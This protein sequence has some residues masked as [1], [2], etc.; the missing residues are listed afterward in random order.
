MKNDIRLLTDAELARALYLLQLTEL[1]GRP[2]LKDDWERNFVTGIEEAYVKF[3]SLTWRQRRRA[4]VIL[5]RVATCLERVTEI[6]G[7]RT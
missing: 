1:A 2:L 5:E 3:G 7:D 6:R 4:R